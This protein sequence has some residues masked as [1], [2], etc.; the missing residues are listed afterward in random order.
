M[1]RKKSED[2][3]KV[4][5]ETVDLGEMNMTSAVDAGLTLIHI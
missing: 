3:P 2:T 5:V 4:E 1:A